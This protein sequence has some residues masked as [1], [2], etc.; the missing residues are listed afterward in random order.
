MNRTFITG[1]DEKTE[2]MLPWFL[3]NYKKHNDLPITFADFGVS[4]RIRIWAEDNFDKVVT[5]HEDNL[6]FKGNPKWFLKIKALQE[7]NGDRVWIDTDCEILGSIYTIFNYM[8]PTKLNIVRD[9][10]WTKRRS[11]VWYN[12]GVVGVSENTQIDVLLQEWYRNSLVYI[13]KSQS[14]NPIFGD[15][16]ILHEILR[17]P[18]KSLIYINELPNEFNWLRL[19]L[20][21]GEN[22]PRKLIMHWTG[23]KG[24]EEI[25]RKMK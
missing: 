13:N 10:P 14:V 15:Q 4:A 16:D 17:D 2:W 21:D 3:E 12:T 20:L 5:I 7:T 1:C 25:R 6:N 23:A 9:K 11:E 18:M 19:Q 22:S 8:D 24:K